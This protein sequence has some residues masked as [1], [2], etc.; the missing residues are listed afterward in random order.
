MSPMRQAHVGHTA[1]L[2]RGSILVVAGCA[3]TGASKGL[4][5]TPSVERYDIA[6]DFWQVSKCFPEAV[7]DHASCSDENTVYVSGGKIDSGEIS[8]KFYAYDNKNDVWLNKGKMRHVRRLHA[9]C[10]AEEKSVV[11][12]IGGADYEQFVR[13][14]E[15]Y[16]VTTEQISS[17]S[18]NTVPR[19]FAHACVFYHDGDI[20]ICG[21]IRS[22]E[23]RGTNAIS[24]Y[25]TRVRQWHE[26]CL[27]LQFPVYGASGVLYRLP[28]RM[29][30]NEHVS[31]G[32]VKGVAI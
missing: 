4:A 27:K 9:M 28:W 1:S 17:W 22:S 19:G 5:R 21:G 7:M 25:D 20:V 14:M 26:T 3:H 13:P 29:I 16:C 31:C 24:K 11:Y 6:R 18:V 8:D 30:P 12:I 15:Q 10:F 2:L 23:H 32:T